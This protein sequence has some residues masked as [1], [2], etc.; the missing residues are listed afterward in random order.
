MS[1]STFTYLIFWIY[2][3]NLL[4][5]PNADTQRQAGWKPEA[6]FNDQKSQIP[7]CEQWNGRW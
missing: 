4:D 5:V 6:S 2:F 1:Q 3:V 7:E